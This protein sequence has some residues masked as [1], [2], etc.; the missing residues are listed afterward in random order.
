M[1]AKSGDEDFM[2]WNIGLESS[3]SRIYG[4]GLE[5]SLKRGRKNRVGK[6]TTL[7]D[8]WMLENTLDKEDRDGKHTILIDGRRLENSLD[9]EDRDEKRTILIDGWGLENSLKWE[10]RN[11]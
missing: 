11:D 9:K 10:E 8:G 1:E 2:G 7:I 3:L 6:H 4:R 5:N